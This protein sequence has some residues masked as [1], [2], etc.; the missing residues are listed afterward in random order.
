[1]IQKRLADMTDAQ[2]A[3][4]L[5]EYSE[6]LWHKMRMK[7]L[8]AIRDFNVKIDVTKATYDC[9]VMGRLVI[10]VSRYPELREVWDRALCAVLD[11]L[12]AINDNNGGMK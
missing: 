10:C 5:S 2:R 7:R 4:H 3:V 8:A 6:W 11:T 1:M 9:Y 12:V